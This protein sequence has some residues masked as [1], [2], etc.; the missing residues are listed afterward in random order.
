[1]KFL[2]HA[3]TTLYHGSARLYS[4]QCYVR[5]ARPYLDRYLTDLQSRLPVRV[6]PDY[7]E[8]VVEVKEILA[9][10]D[11]IF[12]GGGN[13]YLPWTVEV[14]LLRILE[15]MYTI[16]GYTLRLSTLLSARFP[17]AEWPIMPRLLQWLKTVEGYASAEALEEEHPLDPE[18]FSVMRMPVQFFGS[19]ET[20]LLYGKGENQLYVYEPR[21]ALRLVDIS[22]PTTIRELLE[23]GAP[24]HSAEPY[25][26]AV[27]QHYTEVDLRKYRA[28]VLNHH[29]LEFYSADE[30]RRTTLQ[31]RYREERRNLEQRYRWERY[32]RNVVTP[33]D[34][35]D[36]NGPQRWRELLAGQSYQEM[37]SEE[38]ALLAEQ[39]PAAYDW[40][41]QRYGRTVV[42]QVM[43]LLPEEKMEQ[44]PYQLVSRVFEGYK[45][46]LA[47]VT[48]AA[49]TAEVGEW[50]EK[51][52][53]A[54]NNFLGARP[55]VD[56]L[57]VW[58]AESNSYWGGVPGFL[59][60]GLGLKYF[61]YFTTEI[62]SPRADWTLSQWQYLWRGA[63]GAATAARHSTYISDTMLVYTFTHSEFFQRE[64][65]DGWWCSA[66]PEIML[67][68]PADKGSM[69][70][71]TP[72]YH[73]ERCRY[74]GAETEENFLE[75]YA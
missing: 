45:E 17:S 33:S 43:L 18:F 48:Y 72:T 54:G 10:G 23:P 4:I 26:E 42:E 65:L 62:A 73:T 13:P 31:E 38:L 56:F 47:D 66:P 44:A 15:E 49:E 36:R 27:L 32:A 3:P 55:E 74:T 9:K 71:Y 59:Y 50:L 19:R 63:R 69:R 22:D 70:K 12:P 40:V 35:R 57:Q 11:L 60:H 7:E 52:V 58:I 51:A 1:M 2:L 5:R 61:D 8:W 29:L 16:L 20:A 39:R 68:R 34:W 67:H 41:V 21:K 25:P 6:A 64:R 75:E 37:L 24:F 53:K 28:S 14:L 46:D 30:P